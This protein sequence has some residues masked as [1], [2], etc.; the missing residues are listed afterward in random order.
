[1][2]DGLSVL[3]LLRGGFLS[4]LLTASHGFSVSPGGGVP[5]SS[6]SAPDKIGPLGPLCGLRASYGD[7]RVFTPLSYLF[8]QV[9]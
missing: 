1:M 3:C 9:T 8:P 2:A 5:L 4:T 7:Q 6:H